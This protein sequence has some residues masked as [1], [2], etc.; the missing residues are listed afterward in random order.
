[1]QLVLYCMI[2]F[3]LLTVLTEER[4]DRRECSVEE[5][6]SLCDVCFGS[7]SRSVSRNLVL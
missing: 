5:I 6:V 1:M 4:F 2:L 3:I 7:S